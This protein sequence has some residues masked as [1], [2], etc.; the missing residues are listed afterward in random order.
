VLWILDN[1][2]IHTY[3]HFFCKYI[4]IIHR[5]TQTQYKQTC[6]CTQM[7]A[8]CGN[9]TR[10]LLRSRRVFP[11]LRHIGRR[12]RLT[13]N[14]LVK[15]KAIITDMSICLG[16]HENGEISRLCSRQNSNYTLNCFLSLGFALS[17]NSFVALMNKSRPLVIRSKNVLPTY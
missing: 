9:R 14:V 12:M 17:S 13:M 4:H 10:D 11:Q 5:N 6:S 8:L 1:G 16:C 15:L 7:F 3:I 2:L